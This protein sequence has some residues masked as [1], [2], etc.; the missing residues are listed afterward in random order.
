MHSETTAP[1]TSAHVQPVAFLG[2]GVMGY[3]MAGHLARAGHAVTVYNRSPE[4][5]RRW[6]EAHR[7]LGGRVAETPAAAA[8]G[9]RVVFA[10]V[11]NDDDLRQITTGPQGAFGGM[12]RGSVFV[13]HTTASASVARELCQTALAAGF[14]FV[15]A[16]VS[17]GQAG[18]EGATLTIMCGG[19]PAA[20][21]RVQP[22]MQAY[23]RAITRI[24]DSG[25]G[26]L[27]KMVNQ[28]CIAGLIQSL[29]EGI[30]F[31]ERAGLDMKLVLEVIGK[32]A[33]Q[34]WQMQHRGATMIEGRFDFG[35]AVEWM[36]KDLDICLA[37]AKNNGAQIPV[38]T[39]VNQ[40]YAQIQAMGG[41]RWD[42]S[43]LIERLRRLAPPHATTMAPRPA[44]S[45][46][47][48]LAEPPY[49]MAPASANG[50]N[51]ASA[52]PTPAVAV[53][54]AQ[55][56]AGMRPMLLRLARLQ[57]RNDTW[58][59]DAVSETML[60]A[61]EGLASFSAKAQ[62]RTWV[63]G[64]LKHKIIDQLRR[65]RREVSM[66]AQQESGNEE[67][68][69]DFFQ[70]DGHRVASP[71]EW[72]D[73]EAQLS[74]GQFL[75]VLQ[76]CLDRLPAPLARTFLLRE[77]LELDT[78]EVCKEMQVTSTNCFVMLYRARL[79]LRECLNT[80]WFGREGAGQHG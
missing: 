76:A 56:I 74:R 13:D 2:L 52:S 50:P 38:A 22:V 42:T 23:A 71:L 75:A 67:S 5:A 77:W 25:A 47:T 69:D 64:I 17:G 65:C 78:Q 15:D 4:K 31:G 29:A 19:D 46:A 12:Q 14:D 54:R 36:R 57:L 1:Q 32:G 27:A 61:V 41:A 66:E 58:A 68:L 53:R 80:D 6:A 33:A 26:Q 39:L 60:A 35:F 44:A 63:V 20:L 18:A 55:D 37:E 28:L 51:S 72:G 40:Y 10:C 8:R 48:V 49:S 62:L 73:P 3:P 11:G 21:A 24:G 30:H 59:E 79:R 45:L 70:A 7:E 43:S 16:P 34:S 9:A